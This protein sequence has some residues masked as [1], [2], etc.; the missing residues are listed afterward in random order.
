MSSNA[1]HPLQAG[2]VHYNEWTNVVILRKLFKK[3]IHDQV[4]L[5]D[6]THQ[7]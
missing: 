4:C 5:K 6:L 1:I 3:R 7:C 2:N